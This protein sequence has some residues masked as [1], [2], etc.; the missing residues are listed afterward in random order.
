MLEKEKGQLCE[1]WVEVGAET[2]GRN[3]GTL[4]RWSRCQRR[5]GCGRHGK[6]G[7]DTQVCT[8]ESLGLS[9]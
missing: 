2:E 9:S 4:S 7:M 6:A 3:T 5:G 8:E 1:G